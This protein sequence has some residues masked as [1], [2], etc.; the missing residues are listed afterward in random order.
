MR[1]TSCA[2]VTGFQTC[3]LP[4]WRADRFRER[5]LERRDARAGGE[6]IVTE[7]GCDR[8]DVVGLD[9]LTAIG[10]KPPA[11]AALA[12]RR[13]R[14]A[15]SSHSRLLSLPY[16]NSSGTGRAPAARW[17]AGSKPVKAGATM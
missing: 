7:C 16:R 12:S 8:L 11:H 1:H 13:R 9:R 15:G 3:A 4:I 2:L 5:R 14:A 17:G 6:I 10:Q